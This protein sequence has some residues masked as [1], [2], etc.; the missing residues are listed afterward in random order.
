MPN[1]MNLDSLLRQATR[2]THVGGVNVMLGDGSVRTGHELND[3]A[4]AVVRSHPRGVDAIVIGQADQAGWSPVTSFQSHGII[5]ILIG[6]LLPAVQK[7]REAAN[8]MPST[9]GPAVAA[10]G[11][12][13]R[14]LKPAGKV[15][16]VD[17]DGKLLT[18]N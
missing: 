8:R 3:I 14:S 4:A 1:F 10:L 9:S 13:Q 2:S 12:L 7:A 18:L 5:A 17:G 6:L 15:Y 11:T 16:V